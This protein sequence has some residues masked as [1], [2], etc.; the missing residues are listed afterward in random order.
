L[1]KTL[2]GHS[3]QNHADRHQT[4]SVNIDA[5]DAYEFVLSTLTSLPDSNHEAFLNRAHLSPLAGCSRSAD[6][7]EF[8]HGQWPPD[9]CLQQLV[10]RAYAIEFAFKFLMV[11]EI[12]KAI[13]RLAPFPCASA[14]YTTIQGLKVISERQTFGAGDQD[15]AATCLPIN[16][17][18]DPR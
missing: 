4:L 3:S 15:F 6:L 13:S 7:A 18:L 5:H 12:F 16:A 1:G 2:S 10:Y 14:L 17:G 11:A 9:R 8:V